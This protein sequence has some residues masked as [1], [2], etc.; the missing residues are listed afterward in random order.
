[1]SERSDFERERDRLVAEIAESLG[2]CVTSVNQLNRNIETVNSVGQGFDSVSNLWNQF[3]QVMYQS[4]EEAIKPERILERQD[5]ERLPA[6]VVPGG[7]D[8][9]L[10]ASTRT[11]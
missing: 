2:K 3:S 4:N 1:M 5:A 6:G 7:G 11:T 10:S 8:P 9:I